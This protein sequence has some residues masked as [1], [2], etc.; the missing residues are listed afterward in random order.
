[1]ASIIQTERYCFWFVSRQRADNW[2]RCPG[3]QVN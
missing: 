2:I 3:A 1:M